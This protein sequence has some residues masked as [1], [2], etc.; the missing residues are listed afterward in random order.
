MSVVWVEGVVER[1][2]GEER[3]ELLLCFD[4]YLHLCALLGNE[5]GCTL[6]NGV[7]LICGRLRQRQNKGKEGGREGE[8]DDDTAL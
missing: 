4:H 7:K 8:G 3:V 2:E 6:D 5:Q 1:E